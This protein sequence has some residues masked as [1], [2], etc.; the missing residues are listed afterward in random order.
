MVSAMGSYFWV[1]TELPSLFFFKKFSTIS[2]FFRI[3]KKTWTLD[4]KMQIQIIPPATCSV[5]INSRKLQPKQKTRGCNFAHYSRGLRN[6][7]GGYQISI[8]KTIVL[9]KG[10]FHSATQFGSWFLK[11]NN[12]AQVFSPWCMH[13]PQKPQ[14]GIQKFFFELLNFMWTSGSYWY[15]HI[16]TE[17]SGNFKTF[18]KENYAIALDSCFLFT[19]KC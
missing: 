13:T 17:G 9:K 19:K 6:Q 11:K 18:L 8:T 15:K 3:F 16:L 10:S 5:L 2:N 7:S 12:Q 4:R 14:R 1:P